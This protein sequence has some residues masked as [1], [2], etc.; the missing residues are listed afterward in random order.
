M[1]WT[2]STQTYIG[3]WQMHALLMTPLGINSLQCW[4]QLE[5]SDWQESIDSIMADFEEEY[6]RQPLYTV[7]FS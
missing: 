7:C 1:W 3:C 2:P 4:S 5:E 6:G